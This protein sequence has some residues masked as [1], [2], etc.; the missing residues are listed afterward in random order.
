MKLAFIS[1][2]LG[3]I[4][5][6]RESSS[7][8]I[9]L[10]KVAQSLADSFS[11]TIYARRGKAQR[12]VESHG[13]VRYRR[14]PI[15]LDPWLVNYITKHPSL[16][17]SE[18]PVFTSKWYYRTYMAR[19][20]KAL[21]ED[22]ADIVF[23][24][25]FAQFVPII[26]A[27]NPT[28]KIVL[29]MQCEWLSQLDRNWVLD[30]I[31]N[32]DLIIGDSNYITKKIT[33]RFPELVSK[34]TTVYNGVDVNHF[35]PS[36]VSQRG[37]GNVLFVGRVS[38]EKGVH[39]LVDAFQKVVQHN[40]QAQLDIVGP[41]WIAPLEFIVGLSGEPSLAELAQFYNGSYVDHLKRR[42]GDLGIAEHVRFVGGVEHHR[43]VEYYHNADVV[44]NPS[45]SESFG[46]TLAEAMACGVPVIG[47]RIGGMPEIIEEGKTGF[48]IQAGDVDAL[49]SA[50]GSLLS[51]DE[52]RV[53]MGKAARQCVVQVFSW[54]KI[55]ESLLRS[56]EKIDRRIGKAQEA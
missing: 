50:I 55:T 20:A 36:T 21:Q 8:G 43:L 1:Q 41:E 39:V 17:G 2:P 49:A 28:T 37:R 51:N 18:L 3:P 53:K 47:S 22:G 6:S 26:K 42:A 40:P 23:L 4:S 25:N 14:V 33:A 32:V 46:M 48:L 16:V 13:G 29:N 34:C 5:P 52:V 35:V 19:V 9:W 44:V 38:P 45:F 12:D 56:Y 7:L 15:F 24:F 30:N 10:I 54:E 11:V 31:K 27:Y